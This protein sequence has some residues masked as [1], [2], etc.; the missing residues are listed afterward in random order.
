M[1]AGT[2]TKVKKRKP[3]VLKRAKQAL[4]HAE[5]NRSQRTRVRSLIRKL[6]AALDAKDAAA[7]G[8]VFAETLSA[9]D[10]AI[11]D[12]ILHE[13]TAN[14]TKSRLSIAYNAVRAPKAS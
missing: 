13:N 9:I 14:R 4:V 7:A 8:A 11:S 12:G 5:R 3:S 2:P 10:R 1:P 6:R